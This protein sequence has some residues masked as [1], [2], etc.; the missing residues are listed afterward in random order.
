MQLTSTSV[1]L[2]VGIF[3][4]IYLVVLLNSVIVSKRHATNET[5]KFF[6]FDV[7]STHDRASSICNTAIV[8]IWVL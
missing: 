1:F 3:Y 7:D 5:P 6:I 8:L 2:C 4:V